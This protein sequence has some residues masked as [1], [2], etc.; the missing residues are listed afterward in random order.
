VSVE[1]S[2]R[3]RQWA[4]TARHWRLL[5]LVSPRDGVESHVRRAVEKTNATYPMRSE[6][7]SSSR[8]ENR[9]RLGGLVF[10]G[11]AGTHLQLR[12]V[13]KSNERRE[14]LDALIDQLDAAGIEGHLEHLPTRFP[15]AD[16]L[17]RQ[18]ERMIVSLV[19][20]TH[21]EGLLATTHAALTAFSPPS[22][23]TL[24]WI[25]STYVELEIPEDFPP[26]ASA[27]FE[28]AHSSTNAV[29]AAGPD[30]VELHAALDNMAVCEQHHD[31]DRLANAARALGFVTA[32]NSHIDYACVRTGHRGLTWDTVNSDLPSP[33]TNGASSLLTAREYVPDA[34]GVQVVSSRHLERAR[35]LSTWTIKDLG[36][37]RFLL[38]AADLRPWLI[39]DVPPDDVLTRARA[40][41]GDMIATEDYLIE[42]WRQRRLNR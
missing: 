14:W 40:D 3:T 4:G 10:S 19:T 25:D 37:D 27:M 21:S 7:A 12:A 30:G 6:L 32:V 8:L 42:L 28:D 13:G 15:P 36:T 24:V 2:P 22:P 23:Q 33:P 35:D 29:L 39:P 34:Y 16:Y 5:T 31:R 9:E 18:H 11:K 1:L 17:A 41:F 38:A 20:W 26:L